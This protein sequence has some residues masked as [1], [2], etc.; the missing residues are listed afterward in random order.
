[1][2]SNGNRSISEARLKRLETE[3]EHDPAWFALLA[4]EVRR[5]RALIVTA[6]EAQCDMRDDYG[7]QTEAQAIREERRA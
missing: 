4:A 3:T 1:M 2:N 7:L 5:L 6:A